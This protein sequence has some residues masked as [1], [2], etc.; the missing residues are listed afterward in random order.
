MFFAE[1]I[2]LRVAYHLS[3]L[4]SWDDRSIMVRIF[5]KSAKQPSEMALTICSSIPR[6]CNCFRLIR[7][8]KLENLLN[9]EEIFIIPF[10]TEKK[11][12]L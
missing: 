8:W 11:D 9:G 5:P 10:P 1:S 7:D 3:E 2:D 12:Y 6:T 4:T